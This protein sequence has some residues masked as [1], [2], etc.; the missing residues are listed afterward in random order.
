MG[1]SM[2]LSK[3]IQIIK[4]EISGFYN[5]WDMNDE[6]SIADRYYEKKLGI[7]TLPKGKIDAEKVGY[8]T[9]MWGKKIDTPIPVYK[10]PKSLDGFEKYCRGVLL[11]NG[12]LYLANSDK[13]MHDD[14]L[15]M[16]AEKGLIPLGKT[17][18]YSTEYPEEFVAVE[19]N[20][21]N[22]FTQSTA[23]N[24][25]PIYYAQM[26]DDANRKHPYKFAKVQVDEQLDPNW[27]ISYMPD[28]YEHNILDESQTIMGIRELAE[29]A[30]RLGVDHDVILSMLQDEFRK[31]GDAG[32]E[33]MFRGITGV[34]IKTM[35]HGKYTFKY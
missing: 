8:V 25:F 23:Y 35:S 19:K 2:K 5:D 27:L 31:N 6:P 11:N 28:G 15:K 12:D 9:T 18:N 20:F 24:D 3:I 26:F 13:T 17:Y 7:T 29:I 4:E 32:V 22:S 21:D 34:Q 33:E 14:L 1:F 30:S 16:L 10:N